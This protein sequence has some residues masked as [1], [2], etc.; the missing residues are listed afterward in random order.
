VGCNGEVQLV[1]DGVHVGFRLIPPDAA[2]TGSSASV[3]HVGEDVDGLVEVFCCSRDVVGLDPS[4]CPP[5]F[6]VVEAIEEAFWVFLSPD[7]TW[8]SWIG[9]ERLECCNLGERTW[10]PLG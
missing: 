5:P 9:V 1:G 2:V 10:I 7:N 6:V 8:W 3:L 4:Q